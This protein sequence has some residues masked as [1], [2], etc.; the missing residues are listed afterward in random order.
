MKEDSRFSLPAKQLLAV[1][2]Q[3]AKKNKNTFHLVSFLFSNK[4]VGTQ[5][6]QQSKAIHQ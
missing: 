1:E 6:V 3:R 4:T 5:K 2:Q